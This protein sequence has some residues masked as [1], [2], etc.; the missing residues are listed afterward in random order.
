MMVNNVIYS[1][2][3]GWKLKNIHVKDYYNI[4]VVDSNNQKIS[5]QKKKYN[6][7]PL[8]EAIYGKK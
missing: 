5:N 4:Q 2:V 1:Y 3:N 7:D 6:R 8:S